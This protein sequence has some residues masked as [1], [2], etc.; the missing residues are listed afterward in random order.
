MTIPAAVAYAVCLALGN[1]CVIEPEARV[2]S[3]VPEW[4]PPL[5]CM[6]PCDRTA[7]MSPILYGETAACGPGMPWNTEVLIFAP[8]GQ[9]IE[10]RCQD[11]GGAIT[12]DRIDIAMTPAEHE[13][14]PLYGNW[15]VLWILPAPERKPKSIGDIDEPSILSFPGAGRQLAHVSGAERNA[16][17]QDGDQFRDDHRGALGQAWDL[18]RPPS[19]R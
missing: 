12:D 8:W 16:V 2:T 14:R 15:P 5:Q 4:G 19:I 11:R 9:V 13:A 3:Y 17:R 10:R 7:F 6:E 1:H 18:R